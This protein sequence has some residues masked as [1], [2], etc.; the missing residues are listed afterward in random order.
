[1]IE[2]N[3]ETG[4]HFDWLAFAF[5]LR[6]VNIFCCYFRF[7]VSL[8][9]K[10]KFSCNW[11]NAWFCFFLFFFHNEANSFMG[12][13]YSFFDRLCNIWWVDNIYVRLLDRFSYL[14][15]RNIIPL[16][17]SWTIQRTHIS[18][19]IRSDKTVLNWLWLNRNGR[20]TNWRNKLLWIR[21]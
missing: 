15:F 10:I 1:M 4:C 21:W 2:L 19:R 13:V 17:S 14:H 8:A 16:R 5:F 18:R 12:L 20:G 9:L 11:H 6:L 7:W 3:L